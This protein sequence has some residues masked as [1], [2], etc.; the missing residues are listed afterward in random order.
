MP[1]KLSM[2]ESVGTERL[3]H[4]VQPTVYVLEIGEDICGDPYLTGE[5][6]ECAFEPEMLDVLGIYIFT[7]RETAEAVLNKKCRIC[8]CTWH[9]ACPGGCFW[10]EDDLCSKCAKDK[11]R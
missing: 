1:D 9:K 7:N 10:V 11:R 6:N 4:N 8:G 5:I 2:Y 3:Q